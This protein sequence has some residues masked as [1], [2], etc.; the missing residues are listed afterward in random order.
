MTQD[1]AH[2]WHRPGAKIDY[3]FNWGPFVGADDHIVSAVVTIDGPDG[4]TADA[5]AIVDGVSSTGAAVT[6]GGVL[7]WVEGGA[8][9]ESATVYC[10]VTTDDGREDTLVLN[11][12]VGYYR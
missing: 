7:V 2:K 5:G 11:L 4:M 1:I 10:A 12:V 9:G 3:L 6:A 8:L